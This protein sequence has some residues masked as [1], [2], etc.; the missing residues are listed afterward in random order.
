MSPKYVRCEP[1]LGMGYRGR[2]RRLASG[3]VWKIETCRTC[4][5]RGEREAR[6]RRRAR[7]ITK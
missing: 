5:G 6:V 7:R 3:K 4:R 1:C 2:Y